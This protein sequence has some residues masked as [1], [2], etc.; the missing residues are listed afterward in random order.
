MSFCGESC[1]EGV[2]RRRRRFNVY[3]DTKKVSQRKEASDSL[4]KKF[5]VHYMLFLLRTLKELGKQIGIDFYRI[6]QDF[7]TNVIIHDEKLALETSVYT[8]F[9]QEKFG[10]SLS[11]KK[12]LPKS[13]KHLNDKQIKLFKRYEKQRA[14]FKKNRNNIKLLK[15]SEIGVTFLSLKLK[16]VVTAYLKDSSFKKDIESLFHLEDEAYVKRYFDAAVEYRNYFS[17]N[18]GNAKKRQ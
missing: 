8:I 13:K 10:V 14:H 9:T 1:N 15:S 16:D 4:F 12:K 5:K 3:Q 11:L 7:V 17:N 6:S 2:L 18:Y